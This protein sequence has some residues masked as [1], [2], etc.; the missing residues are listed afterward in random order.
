MAPEPAALP[1]AVVAYDED[2]D[3]EVGSGDDQSA[4]DGETE[5]GRSGC[6]CG[7][8]GCVSILARAPRR[9]QWQLA[10]PLLTCCGGAAAAVGPLD[11]TSAKHLVFTAPT[12][13][14]KS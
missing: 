10:V 2:A 3:D 8:A 12:T 9:H 7:T 4:S 13:L 11:S 5:Y 14:L 1:A 6:D